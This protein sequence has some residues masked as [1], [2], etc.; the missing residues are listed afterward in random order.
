MGH[1]ALPGV[2]GGTFDKGDKDGRASDL[3]IGRIEPS[4]SA[5]KLSFLAPVRC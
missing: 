3:L 2:T 4:S 5:E 1:G